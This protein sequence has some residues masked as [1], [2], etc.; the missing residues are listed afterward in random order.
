MVARFARRG[1]LR[2][3]TLVFHQAKKGGQREA[4]QQTFGQT[5]DP[6]ADDASQAGND[7][8]AD[9]TESAQRLIA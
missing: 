2:S 4:Q 6:A 5:Q 1:A 8:S 9:Q 3:S 7:A